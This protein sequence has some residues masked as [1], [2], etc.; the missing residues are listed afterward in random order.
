MYFL[1]LIAAPLPPALVIAYGVFFFLLGA[2]VGSFLNVVIWRLPNRGR[3]I[4]YQT[5]PGKLT[6]SWP[7][8]H[9]PMC[10]ASILW[11]QNIPVLSW[12]FLRARCAHC[13]AHIPVRY[14]LV[15]LGTACAFLGLFLAYF[16]AHWRGGFTNLTHDWPAY[17]LHLV[18]IACLLAASAIDADL[19]IIP[20]SI[21]WFLFVVTLLASPF[22]DNPVIPHIDP[23]GAW[24]RA[25]VGG[26]VGVLLANVLV[27]LKI[28][29]RAFADM[30][31]EPVDPPLAGEVVGVPAAEGA[32][33]VAS[34][35]VVAVEAIPVGEGPLAPPP[36]LTRF[37]LS[38]LVAGLLLAV[39][40]AA[41]LI[42]SAFVA[43]LIFLSAGLV[44]FLI[45]VLP[46]DA[47]QVDVTDE[48][49]EEISADYV[50]AEVAKEGLF[51]FTVMA[52]AV[53]AWFLP[54][55][56][57]AVAWLSR[58]LGVLLGGL[59]GGAMIWFT[60]VG[61]TM[62]FN[63]EAMGRG[64]VDLLMA[65]GGILGAPMAIFTFFFAPVIALL[66]VIVIKVLKKPNVLPLGPWLSVAAILTLLVGVPILNTYL[67]TMGVEP[68]VWIPL[69]PPGILATP[70]NPATIFQR[71]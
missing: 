7:P 10:D 6:L 24:A 49:L 67:A 40:V 25:T 5:T 21:P 51:L 39:T 11:Y 15:E 27:W 36:K 8:S 23:A 30:E 46:R 1:S 61:F 22:I 44:I 71:V 58:L 64:D 12:L 41:F 68:I 37:H 45:G 31:H 65:I 48:V 19:F 62:L 20:L 9:C 42:F 55:H 52:C 35:P 43:T 56:F 33:P 4:I 63:K 38:L 47:G 3:E 14:P 59:V 34:P 2:C 26:V 16:V 28:L 69:A 50:R 54:L 53:V 32:A 17:V 18:M 60:R 13:R 57:P 70:P 29:P 66:W